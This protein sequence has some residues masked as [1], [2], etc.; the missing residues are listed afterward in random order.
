MKI[1]RRRLK[2]LIES[3]ISGALDKDGA[4]LSAI[5]QALKESPAW[6]KGHVGNPS[7]HISISFTVA[8]TS[9]KKCIQTLQACNPMSCSSHNQFTK[10]ALF[11]HRYAL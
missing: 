8:S 7:G 10:T 2:F 3:A 6:K 11:Y 9:L 4:I 1:T 5:N